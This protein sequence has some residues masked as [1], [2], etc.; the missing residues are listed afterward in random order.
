MSALESSTRQLARQVIESCIK[1]QM[2]VIAAESMTGGLFVSEL[3]DIENASQVI[4]RSFI[5]YSDRSKSEI[6]NVPQ[7]VIKAYSVYSLEVVREMIAGLNLLSNAEI[8]VAISGVAGP[9]TYD[10]QAVGSVY[11]ALEFNQK[12]FVYDMKFEGSRHDIRYQ[13]VAFIYQ[14][15]LNRMNQEG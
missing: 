12:V 15:I 1:K 2:H 13:T 8:K 4:D 6:L 10:D 3:T 14:E 5:V 7:S 9:K 11:I